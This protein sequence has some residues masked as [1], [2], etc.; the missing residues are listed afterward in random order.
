MTGTSQDRAAGR[1]PV[2]DAV[3]FDQVVTDHGAAVLRVC[4][5]LV[6][7]HEAGDAWSDTFVS[8]MRSYPDLPAG[9]NVRAWLLTIARRR[10]ID[11]L[12]RRGRSPVPTAEVPEP[13]PAAADP[14]SSHA[15]AQL[16]DALRQLPPRQR[17]AV[18]YRYLA[19]LDYEHVG[20]LL[21]SNATA[22]RRSAADG[23]AALRA[24]YRPEED[25]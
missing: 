19:D 10:S 20:E 16:F 11:Q 2:V 18:A 9:S 15:D 13:T 4:R 8:A 21:G 1:L 17:D 23:I 7:P 14:G 12:R 6:G 24:T 3:A 25:R 22:A 5:A